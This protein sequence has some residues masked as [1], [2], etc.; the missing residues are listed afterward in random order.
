MIEINVTKGTFKFFTSVSPLKSILT[1]I[2][3]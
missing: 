1:S 2:E 3:I